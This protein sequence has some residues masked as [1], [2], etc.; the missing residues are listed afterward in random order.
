LVRDRYDAGLATIFALLSSEEARTAYAPLVALQVFREQHVRWAELRDTMYYA[1]ESGQGI[2]AWLVVIPP[3]HPDLDSIPTTLSIDPTATINVARMKPQ[4]LSPT[5]AGVALIHELSHLGDRALGLE[6][7]MPTRKQFLEGELRAYALEMMALDLLTAGKFSAGLTATL[8]Q[9]MP[10]SVHEVIARVQPLDVG[11]EIALRL[12]AGI[13]PAESDA[14]RLVRRGLY[15]VALVLAYIDSKGLSSDVV[16]SA[17]DA[18][19]P[20]GGPQ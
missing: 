20:F 5:W 10:A 2:A 8:E 14:E 9:W 11:T 4:L 18:L 1:L 12:W 17:L 19:L 16:L 3:G 15:V 13:D 6:P 7:M